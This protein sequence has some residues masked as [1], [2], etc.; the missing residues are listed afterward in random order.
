MPTLKPIFCAVALVGIHITK[1]FQ[2]LLIDPDTNYS[3]LAV[4]FPKFYEE[5]KMIDTADLVGK[6][7]ITL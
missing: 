7:I 3:S 2:A 1:P 5:L 4:A 6:M